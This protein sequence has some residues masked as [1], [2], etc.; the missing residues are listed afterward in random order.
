[1]KRKASTTPISSRR[2]K[3][4]KLSTEEKKEVARIAD[5]QL[6]KR[7]DV[8]YTDLH[9]SVSVDASGF[10]FDL[11]TNLAFSDTGLNA[12]EG[13]S[14]TPKGLEIRYHWNTDQEY[15][16]VRTIIFQ[17]FSAATPAVTDI[18]QD[19]T[20]GASNP[21]SA[22]EINTKPFYKILH[23]ALDVINT[24]NSGLARALVRKV[25]INGKKLRKIRSQ[26][27]ASTLVN[28]RIYC[29]VISD[30]QVTTYPAFAFYSRLS[31][32]DF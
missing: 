21:L 16:N 26:A 31:Y 8:K 29:L 30:D 23:D 7:A 4:S 6:L 3:A 10:L 22:P 1:M 13:N 19:I 11:T 24:Y 20:I 28:G 18:L 27:T 9:D 25:Y 14:I 5:Q 17:W 15:S 2:T 12:Y 32:Y